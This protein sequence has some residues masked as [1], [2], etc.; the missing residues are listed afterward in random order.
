MHKKRGKTGKKNFKFFSS[1]I[2]INKIWNYWRYTLIVPWKICVEFRYILESLLI[3]WFWKKLKCLIDC[4]SGKNWDTL[5]TNKYLLVLLKFDGRF[6][7]KHTP[8]FLTRVK[9]K[10]KHKQIL[11]VKNIILSLSKTVT[12]C[13]K[14][15]IWKDLLLIRKN[16]SY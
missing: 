5:L 9:I 11:R 16:K 8:I 12:S 6:D 4:I 14:Q 10:K 1:E 15:P 7:I 3:F 13:R 2:P